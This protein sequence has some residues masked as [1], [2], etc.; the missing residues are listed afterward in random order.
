MMFDVPL[1]GHTYE[2]TKVKWMEVHEEPNRNQ[3]EG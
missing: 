2:S 3:D 1:Q